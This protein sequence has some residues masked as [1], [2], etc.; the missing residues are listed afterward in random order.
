VIR[1]AESIGYTDALAQI[2]RDELKE[3]V[4]LELVLL[5]LD[6]KFSSFIKAI[7]KH[8][9]GGSDNPSFETLDE[10][11]E[12]IGVYLDTDTTVDGNQN[13]HLYIVK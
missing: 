8:M 3:R 11:F 13:R 5:T 12:R 1:K 7:K 2:A 6:R 10:Y 4:E 9:A